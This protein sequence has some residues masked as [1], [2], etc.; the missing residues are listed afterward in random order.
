MRISGLASGLDVDSMVKELMKARKSSYDTMIKKRTQVEWQRD[1]YRSISSKI[2]DFRNNKLSNYNLSNA[3]NAKTSQIAGDTSAI[4]MNT[5]SSTAAGIMTV[6]VDRV[7]TSARE[8]YTV[9]QGSLGATTITINGE[10]ITLEA[11][12][13]TGADL[14][15]AIN[16]NMSKTKATALYN[17]NTGELSITA[18]ETGKDKLIISSG[19]LV[20][21]NNPGNVEGVEARVIINGMEYIQD[22]NRFVVNGVDFTVKAKSTVD[23]TIS[24][25]KDTS[26]IMDTIKSFVS[27]YNNLLGLINGELSEEKNRTYLPLTSDEKAALSD[28]E[29][30]QWEVKAKSG[31]LR[32]DSTLSKYV[33]DLRNIVTSLIGGADLGGGQRLSVGITTAS[34]TEKGKLVL[35]EE[36]L[37]KALESNPDEVTALFSD[38]TT[39]VF[40]KMMDTSLTTLTDLSKIAG[41]SMSSSDANASFLESSLIGDRIRD[42]KSKES[43]MLA[44][45]NSLETTYYKQFSAMEKAINNFNSQSSAISKL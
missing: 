45:L 23:T 13:S 10:P 42:M 9:G 21:T 35:D 27:E 32:G 5:T 17:A 7:A 25:E 11:S 2:V 4:K 19:P 43:L 31:A 44:R 28:K 24:V 34:Y 15:A 39:G 18:T 12:A 29:V 8:I 3:I 38:S 30:E 40:R 14:A 22:S 37:L 16:A 20:P 33:S 26:K 41:T 1:D 6:N 36:K